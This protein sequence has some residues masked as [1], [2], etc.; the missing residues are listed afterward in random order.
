MSLVIVRSTHCDLSLISLTENALLTAF[1]NAELGR[2]TRSPG[3]F[4]SRNASTIVSMH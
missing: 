1:P 3:H 4:V 2:P